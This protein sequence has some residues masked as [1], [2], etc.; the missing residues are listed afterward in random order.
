M[1]E[2]CSHQC[3]SQSLKKAALLYVVM[4]NIYITQLQHVTYKLREIM[5]VLQQQQQH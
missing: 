4:Y 1:L 5:D 2:K 3:Q